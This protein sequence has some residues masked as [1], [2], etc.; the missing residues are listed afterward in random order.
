VLVVQYTY[1][2]GGYRIILVYSFISKVEVL[3]MQM[4]P[5]DC[6]QARSTKDIY[7]NE[8]T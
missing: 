7:D 2:V 5:S 1:R 8:M 4:V 6:F 3:D